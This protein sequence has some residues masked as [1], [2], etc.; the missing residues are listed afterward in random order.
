[1]NQSMILPRL[2]VDLQGQPLAPED[3]RALTSVR[4]QQRLSAPSQCEL[5]FSDLPRMAEVASRLSP[6]TRLR[7]AQPDTGEALFSGQVTALEY[8]YE[9][10]HGNRLVARAYDGLHQLRKRQQVRAHVQVTAADLAREFAEGSGLHVQAAAPGGLWHH[11]IQHQQS[12]LALLVEVAAKAGLFLTVRDE[13][14][15]LITLDGLGETVPLALGETLFEARIEINA[16]RACRS[17]IASGWNPLRGKTFSEQT[18][19]PVVGRRVRAEVAPAAVGGSGEWHLVDELAFAE[20]Q[21]RDI[22][23][24]ELTVR[25]AHEVTLWGVAEGNPQLR[26]GTPVEVT[27]V[28]PSIAGRYVLT[29]VTHTFDSASGFLSELSSAPPELPARPHAATTTTGIVTRVDDPERLGRVKAKLPTYNNVETDWM[30]V[31][32]TAA[33][34][35]KGLVALP[36][37]GDSVLL[38]FA[39]TDPGA[40]I[41]LGGLFTEAIGA[42]SGVEHGAVR[43]YTLVTRDGQRICLDDSQHSLR[44]ED[45]QGSVIEMAPQAVRVHAAAQLEIEAP[46]HPVIIRGQTID[47]ERA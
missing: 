20:A 43:R 29:A 22:A 7:I 31:L 17:V 26:P 21:A 45:K 13:V 2:L 9:P 37:V 30:R 24:A 15:H 47:F 33:G 1:M 41:V 4:V 32:T 5:T 8:G 18:A 46:G 34:A 36:D 19:E 40:G 16:D 10:A 14:L 3:M 12:D 35:G 23:Q 44:L 6:G 39:A 27:G 38:L 28:D 42:Q 11:L 25:R